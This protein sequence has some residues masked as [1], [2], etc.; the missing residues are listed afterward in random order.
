MAISSLI[1]GVLVHITLGTI[2][3]YSNM[4][5]YIISYIRNH[6]HPVHLR[7]VDAPWVFSSAAVGQSLSM[8]FGGLL[9][10]KLSVRFATAGCSWSL[11]ASC[12]EL[13]QV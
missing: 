6:S 1:G 9:A 7:G 10:H 5:P 13:E 2:Y 8:Y 3:T 4:A 12:M 11:M